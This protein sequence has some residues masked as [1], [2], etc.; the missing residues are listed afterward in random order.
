[1]SNVICRNI[2]QSIKT[3]SGG[4]SHTMSPKLGKFI[5]KHPWLVVSIILII[6]IGFS[7]F[8]PSLEFKTDFEDF[9]PD[10][11]LVKANT[12]I[13]EYFG[14]SQPLVFLLIEKED[15]DSVITIES[16]RDIW[17]LEHEL[18]KLPDVNGSFSLVTFLDIICLI[19]FGESLHNCSDEQIMIALQDL[20]VSQE[21]GPIR[22]FSSDDPNE[23]IDYQRFPR[24]SKGSSVDG[25]DIKNCYFETDNDSLTVTFDVYD[26]GE[27]ENSLHPVFPK[28]NIMEW[29]VTFS[30]LITPVEALNITYTI[31]GHIEPVNSVWEIGNGF[32]QN[33]KNLIYNLRNR[34]LFNQYKKEVYLW[35]QPSGQDIAF[36]ILLQ[37]GEMKFDTTDDQVILDVSLKELGTYGIASQFGSFGL[38]AKLSNFNAGT[39]YYQ[40][41]LFKTGGGYL[42]ANT[43]YLLQKLLNLQTKPLL[44]PLSEKMLQQYGNITWEEFD[45]FFSMIQQVDMLPDTLALKDLQD[46]WKDADHVPDDNIPSMITFNIIPSFYEDLQLSAFSFLSTDYE[47]NGKPSATLMFL[48]L[49]STKDYDTIIE[50]NSRVDKS[51]SQLD[52]EYPE[53]S[54]QVTGNGM[55]SVQIN[56]ITTTAN[57]FIAPLIFIIIMIVLFFNFRRTSYV[58]LPMLTLVIS[59]IWLFGSMALLGIS[60][61]IIAVALVPLIMGLGVDYSVHL[62]HNYRVELENGFPAAE[63]IVNSVS[64]V[65][66]A[67]FLAMIT[68]VIAFLSFL[69]ASIGPVRDFGILLALG[70][71]YTFITALTL[72]PALRY[73]LD[74][75][76]TIKVK[77][78][79]HGVAVRT[80]MRLLSEKILF[81]EK[82]ILAIMITLTVIFAYGATQ[83]QTGFDMN[84]FAPED[85]PAIQLFEVIAEKFPFSSQSQEYILVEGDVATVTALDGIRQSHI[86]LGDDFFIAKN[87]DGSQKIT[88]VYS[89]I[90]QSIKNDPTLIERFNIN[91]ETGVPRSDQDVKALY[92]YLYDGGAMDINMDDVAFAMDDF[93]MDESMMPDISMENFNGELSTVLAKEGSHYVATVIRIYIDPSFPAQDGNVNDDQALLKKELNADIAEYGDATAVAT[94]QYIVTLTIT[95]SLT[96]SQIIS[97]IASV[98]LSALIL[99]I[100]YRN[101][102]LGLIACIPVVISIIWILGTMHFI[103]YTLNVLTIT[104]TS[105]TIGI[106]IDY[107]IHATERFRLIAD[108]T[109][110]PAKSVCETIS[111]TGGALLIAALTT[112][113]GFIVLLFAPIPPQQ[114]FGLIL[115]ITITY[116]FLTS[117]FILPLVLNHWARIR[118][119]KMGYIISK[120]GLVLV[121]GQYV[122]KQQ[123]DDSQRTVYDCTD[124]IKK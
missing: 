122:K 46:N 25:A 20:L 68:T 95:D 6:T 121:N 115:A 49:M 107:A 27:L 62:F 48:Q 71:I 37:S 30:N 72:L 80:V 14:E 73:I 92:D 50:M 116:S 18:K 56:D 69:T 8:I 35:V 42:S 82:I 108:K 97:T 40:T 101:P 117:I 66:T 99:I 17:A 28:V 61:N 100:V 15:A 12:C 39:R 114:Q 2:T 124:Y 96:E 52:R 23:K 89:I 3:S 84:E 45:E 79:P 44:G 74:E 105:M 85:T 87:N 93:D 104:V 51:V 63:A 59:T 33:M 123:S 57:Q 103:G 83:L 77:R 34:S 54:I 111:H 112:V 88:S 75:R 7:F 32:L 36:P 1:M 90:Q 91:E 29:Y 70:V 16:L 98:F 38:P 120:N 4:Y 31:S 24:F 41:P 53:I 19:E 109:G 60:F 106:G 67:M 65:G 11:P 102:V 47:P 26:L 118:K 78:K 21:K 55:I 22:L 110:D 64:E 10:D 43:S 86:K 81:Y 76:R 9:T 119:K 94:G 113:L 5:Q 58:F 13:Q